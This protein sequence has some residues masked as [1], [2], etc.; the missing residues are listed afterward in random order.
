MIKIP[1]FPVIIACII[2]SPV[3]LQGCS[4]GKVAS[5]GSA[6]LRPS[7]IAN[8]PT[9]PGYYVGIGYATKA[10]GENYT[11]IAKENALNDLV[12]TISVR[13]TSTTSLSQ[14]QRDL[15]FREEYESLVKTSTNTQINDYQIVDAWENEDDYWI[16]IRLSRQQYLDEI[17]QKKENAR[18]QAIDFY[19][20]GL[21]FEDSRSFTNALQMYLRGLISMQEY[22]GESLAVQKSG[23][24][25]LLDNELISRIQ[26]LF[27]MVSLTTKQDNYQVKLPLEAPLYFDVKVLNNANRPIEGFPLRGEFSR[28]KGDLLPDTQTNS[29]GEAVCALTAISSSEPTQTLV[30]RPDISRLLQTNQ[31]SPISRLIFQQFKLPAVRVKFSIEKPVIFVSTREMGFDNAAESVL[32]QSLQALLNQSGFKLA[33][34]KEEAAIFIEMEASAK[35]GPV[36]SNI[37]ISYLSI[38]IKALDAATSKQL[39]VSR[40]KEFRGYSS[41]YERALE[42]AYQRTQ[43]EMENQLIDELTTAILQ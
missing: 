14:F 27:N 7:W 21:K 23:Q 36:R 39:Y 43:K 3:L 24:I 22:L 42:E 12:N 16:Y 31:L 2:V 33:K 1:G 6:Q 40:S 4:A 13:V 29:S 5:Q 8:R 38:R 9:P 19:N 17:N 30:V 20:R 37:Y 11:A 28:G 10:K 25:T 26:N 18:R 32:T 15:V 41:S 35:K 34:S